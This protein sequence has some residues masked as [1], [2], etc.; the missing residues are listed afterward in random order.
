MESPKEFTEKEVRAA[1][2]SSLRSSQEAEV[3]QTLGEVEESRSRSLLEFH[4]QCRGTGNQ[5]EAT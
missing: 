4:E 1:L 5:V 3:K 2:N